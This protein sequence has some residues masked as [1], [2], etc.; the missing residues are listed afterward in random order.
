M[1]QPERDE[2]EHS[3]PGIGQYVE[4]GVILAVMTLIEVIIYESFDSG[5]STAVG[6]PALVLLTI[7]KFLLVVMWFMHLRFDHHMFR[8]FFYVG[9]ALAGLVYGIVVANFFLGGTLGFCCT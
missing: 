4:I 7:L 8:R 1:A 2:A 6:I 3:H 5:L 9:V